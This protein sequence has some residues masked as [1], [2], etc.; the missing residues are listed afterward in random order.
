MKFR[1]VGAVDEG[2]KLLFVEA[3]R[4]AAQPLGDRRDVLDAAASP[5]GYRMLA[6]IPRLPMP[7][8]DSTV[9][10]FGS[11]QKMLSATAEDFQVIDGIGAIR[12][13]SLREGLSRLAETA[14]IDRFV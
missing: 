12:A 8:V 11:L 3:V 2:L 9:E 1:G 4:R 6:R 14:L 5:R 7:I 10:H 13:R